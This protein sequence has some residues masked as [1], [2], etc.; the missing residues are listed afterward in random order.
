[1][2]IGIIATWIWIVG[3]GNLILLFLGILVFFPKTFLTR[4]FQDYYH[5]FRSQLLYLLLIIGV[6]VFHLIEVNVLDS[7]ATNLIGLDFAHSLQLIEGNLVYHLARYWNLALVTPSVV[8]Y[9]I[10]YPF[11]LWFT[12]LYFLMTNKKSA[13]QTLSYGL[14]ITYLIAL[15]FYLFF[16]V[17]NVYQFYGLTSALEQ[18]IP[19]INQFF[20]TTTTSNNCLPSLHVAMTLLIAYSISKTHNKKFT[21]FAIICSIGVMLSV[22]YLAIHWITDVV[23]GV[24]ITIV[25]ITLLK[26]LKIGIEPHEK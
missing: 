25:V 4:S 10:I 26:Q 20:Y 9:I 24:I 6:V 5:F 21:Y 14:L 17:T 2:V 23:G 13:M 16:P 22:I 1:M 3:I 12:P 11:T 7:Y 15:P 19:S 18:V 8:I